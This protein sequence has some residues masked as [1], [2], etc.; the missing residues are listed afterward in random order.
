ME[1]LHLSM[2]YIPTKRIY[3]PLYPAEKDS[4]EMK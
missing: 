4:D 3:N 2:G 1:M